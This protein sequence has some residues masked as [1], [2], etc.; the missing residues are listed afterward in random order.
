MVTEAPIL[1]HYDPSSPL[2]IQCDAIQEGLGAAL[3]QNRK[4]MAY[5]SCAL[6]DTKTCYAQIEKEM[7]AIIYALEKFNQFTLLF[8]KTRHSLQ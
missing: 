6:T 2:A 5:A 8:W 1:S 7:L 4:P 3:L